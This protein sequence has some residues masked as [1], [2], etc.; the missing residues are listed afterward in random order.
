MNQEKINY[1]N[2][3]KKI[4]ELTSNIQYLED[5]SLEIKNSTDEYARVF[6]EE[7]KE[8]AKDGRSKTAVAR[9]EKT[10]KA[11]MKDREDV[12]SIIDSNL[13]DIKASIDRFENR[14][15]KNLDSKLGIDEYENDSLD[16]K[17]RIDNLEKGLT[18]EKVTI[19]KKEENG[20][21][22]KEFKKLYKRIDS[23]ENDIKSI[24]KNE[25]IKSKNVEDIYSNN[26]FKKEVELDIKNEI[27]DLNF[28][29]VSKNLEK[30]IKELENNFKNE[31]KRIDEI[32]SEKKEVNI[33]DFVKKDDVEDL[34]VKI[35][36]IQK[37]NKAFEKFNFVE[38]N[39][40]EK[41]KTKI[42]KDFEKIE[43]KSSRAILQNLNRI[44]DI[45]NILKQNNYDNLN[46]KIESLKVTAGDKFKEAN[47]LNQN[48]L[49][50][51]TKKVNAAFKDNIKLEIDKLDYD[52]TKDK[53]YKKIEKL[54]NIIDSK[55]ENDNKEYNDKF[56]SIE[57]KISLININDI[58]K[59]ID[60]VD[61]VLENKIKEN[62]KLNQSILT[63]YGKK[64]NDN[65]KKEIH[66]EI[67]SKN[68]DVD[69]KID[70]IENSINNK[71]NEIENNY[72]TKFNDIKNN[73]ENTINEFKNIVDEKSNT[74][75]NSLNNKIEKSY[76]DEEIE[77]IKN[78]YSKFNED[79][80]KKIDLIEEKIDNQDYN[81]ICKKIETLETDFDSKMQEANVL[82][83]NIINNYGKKL[84]D[85]LNLKLQEEVKKLDYDDDIKNILININDLKTALDT[86]I[87]KT[88]F[89]IAE[90]KYKEEQKSGFEDIRKN[91]VE[92]LAELN[93]KVDGKIDE[94]DYDIL[95]SKISELESNMKNESTNN[96]YK[97]SEFQTEMKKYINN[98]VKRVNFNSDSIEKVHDEL[99]D[100]KLQIK[101]LVD[102]NNDQIKN[103]ERKIK[104]EFKDK[105]DKLDLKSLNVIVNTIEKE[106]TEIK[107]NNSK[108]EEK[109]KYFNAQLKN[110][111]ANQ[112]LLENRIV[113]LQ[114]KNNTTQIESMVNAKLKTM[115][116]HYEKLLNDK[117]IAVQNNVTKQLESGMRA[118]RTNSRG[119]IGS[120]QQDLNGG[121]VMGKPESDGFGGN[122][123]NIYSKNKLQGGQTSKSAAGSIDNPYNNRG[124][125]PN[126]Y[127][128]GFNTSSYSNYGTQNGKSSMFSSRYLDDFDFDDDD[129]EF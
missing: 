68:K 1:E 6:R 101:K 61:E 87:E 89:E 36:D 10:I 19:V 85:S 97:I 109:Y 62:N 56:N 79:K 82:S 35:E 123:S 64:L 53:I 41:L 50:D 44:K 49:N 88:D 12:Q 126:M 129:D 111:I 100:N 3:E 47:V 45:E 28:E 112:Q 96:G 70:N 86:K 59:K 81:G 26:E 98:V 120:R 122:Y 78:E 110:I 103:L 116:N 95:N 92:K 93:V 15:N 118:Q 76:F 80:T 4:R 102:T 58:Y 18:G 99:E 20:V 30:R 33:D 73:T 22:E 48:I 127:D 107:K 119:L 13:E 46:N 31:F 117:I 42:V 121:F 84:K 65:Y 37:I 43:D 66:E 108:N 5:K 8:I 71:I 23:I 11:L 7:L 39:E 27:K 24:N 55:I 32:S 54:E 17:N 91:L 14:L 114:S 60:S 125:K 77:R 63:N 69:T 16:L 9:H 94:T 113:D 128:D 57:N 90:N 74:I 104:T 105:I 67:E 124:R 29:K 21:S 83:Q 2:I 25:N 106:I 75:K 52:N 72:E 38:K 51:Y 40:I 115:Q 34:K